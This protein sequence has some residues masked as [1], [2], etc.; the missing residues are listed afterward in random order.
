MQVIFH[1]I[2]FLV[3]KKIFYFKSSMYEIIES[4]GTDS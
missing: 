4:N 3:K 1:Q 2:I